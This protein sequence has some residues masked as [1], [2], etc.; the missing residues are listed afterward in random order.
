MRRRAGIG[1]W[2]RGFT[3]I[4][5]LVVIS[6]IAG[7]LALAAPRFLPVI[8]YSTH[9]GAARRL[10]SFGSA[11]IA[12]AALRGEKLYVRVDLEHQEYWVERIPDP[13]EEEPLHEDMA[14][15]SLPED[16]AELRQLAQEELDRRAEEKGTDEGQEVLEEQSTR[17]A[18][19]SNMRARK[20]LIAQAARVR[21]DERALPASVREKMNP[22]L[23]R[24]TKQEEMEPEEIT[25]ALIART[26]LPNEVQFAWVQVGGVDAKGKI[27]TVEVGPAGLDAKAEFGL[28]NEAGDVFVVTWDPVSGMTEFHE[29][30]DK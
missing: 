18:E 19:Q 25:T 28:I 6:I 9:E 5:L 23:A 16:D 30:R 12:E 2:A 13:P 27:E 21:H 14:D 17:M 26:T 20:E 7:V 4:E 29:E 24:R 3:L 11:T 1:R 15:D 10:A 8:L 22:S